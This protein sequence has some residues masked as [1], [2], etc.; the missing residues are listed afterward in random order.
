MIALT[1]PDLLTKY[2]MKA[3]TVQNLADTSALAP[4]LSQTTPLNS[5]SSESDI[6]TR[7]A[8]VQ[9]STGGSLDAAIQNVKEYYGIQEKEQA[10]PHT[11]SYVNKRSA[12]ELSKG[13]FLKEQLSTIFSLPG[14]ERKRIQGLFNI[15]QLSRDI[16]KAPPGIL[17][18][19]YKKQAEEVFRAT[20]E[21]WDAIGT[22]NMFVKN[23]VDVLSADKI[24][25]IIK[26]AGGASPDAVKKF[27]ESREGQDIFAANT[28]KYNIP[29]MG[30]ITRMVGAYQLAIDENSKGLSGGTKTAIKG[31]LT[32]NVD[33]DIYKTGESVD[34]MLVDTL[35]SVKEAMEA[36]TNKLSS[37][38]K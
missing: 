10:I 12:K 16:K 20:G 38:K 26:G 28:D 32:N 21:R 13:A 33:G 1:S 30:T 15:E 27:M 7:A 17:N 19:L 14:K 11:G 37:G 5:S 23:R 34:A 6:M 22:N 3:E 36:M 4:L 8:Y 18:S 29:T 31:M 35:K 9:K 2:G 25:A 24:I